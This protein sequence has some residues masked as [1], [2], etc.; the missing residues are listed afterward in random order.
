MCTIPIHFRK[1]ER[2]T[3]PNMVVIR[4]ITRVTVFMKAAFGE[5]IWRQRANAMAPRIIPEYQQTLISPALR[6]N[7]FRVA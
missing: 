6:G 2:R 5:L 4:T 7:Y 3:D 1:E